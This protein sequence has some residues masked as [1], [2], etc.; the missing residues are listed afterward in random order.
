MSG[1]RVYA[2]EGGAAVPLQPVSL[3]EA[4]LKERQDLQEWVLAR[5]EI[6]G[7]DVILVAFEFDRWQDARGDR[8]RDRLDV[9]GMDADGRL[10]LA[11]LKRDQAPDTVEMQAVKYAAMASRFTEADLVTYHARFLSD[12]GGQTVSEDVARARLLDHAGEPD[13]DQLRQPRIVLVA[14]SFTKSTSASVVW[15]TEMGLDITMQRVQAYR[16]GAEGVIVTVSQL[17]PVPDVEEFTISPQRAEAVA[18]QSRKRKTRERS[19][20][21]KLVASRAL[22]D[23]IQLTFRT[24]TEVDAD[25]RELVE[26]W[27]AEDPRRGRALWRN[28]VAKPLTWEYD[29]QSYRPTGIVSQVLQ[30]AA[31]LARSVR[32][33]SWWV[34][35]GDLS[36]VDLAG[37][38]ERSPFDWSQLHKILQTLPPGRWTTY[39]DLAEVVGTAA[40]P[41]GGHVASCPDCSN[42]WRILD[43]SGLPRPGFRLTDQNDARPQHEVLESEGVR[44]DGDRADPAQRLSVDQLTAAMEGRTA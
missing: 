19:A 34:T 1:E 37:Q 25:A 9:L 39:G 41:L 8:Q 3:A 27:I 28:D 4:G 21:Q 35:E 14:G 31:Q 24:T 43:A 22:P 20:V 32:G 29:G 38:L 42:A 12:R 44:F 40:Q 23:G 15:L 18:T 10:V 2:I 6:L 16:I 17:F 30:E 33:T 5:P 13:A 36:L 7:P 26:E 11:E